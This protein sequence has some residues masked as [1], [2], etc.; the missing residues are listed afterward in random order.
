M[1][2]KVKPTSGAA[3][4]G[5]NTQDEAAVQTM[6][7]D[8]S[9]L[10]IAA[11]FEQM[12]AELEADEPETPTNPDADEEQEPGEGEGEE[13]EDEGEDEGDDAGAEGEG[14]EDEGDDEGEDEGEGDDEDEAEGED[15]EKLKVP[16]E[17]QA[18][19]DARIGKEVAKRKEAEES[20]QAQQKVLLETTQQTRELQ[21]KLAQAEATQALSRSGNNTL[22][23]TDDP[24]AI[25][26][27][28]SDINA[29][30]RWAEAN[31][32]GYESEDGS[33]SAEQIRERLVTLRQ[34]RDVEIPRIRES[35]NARGQMD[36]MIADVYP[37]LL[38]PQSDEHRI[39]QTLVAKMPWL[40]TFPGYKLWIGDAMAG[41]KL[42]REAEAKS[43]P[44]KK[45]T[46]VPKAPKTPKARGGPKKATTTTRQEPTI[47]H[48]R[49]A[50]A[51]YDPELVAEMLD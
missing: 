48:K 11:I 42:R 32:D 35:L 17:V 28:V 24:A 5:V 25:E 7:E 27:R 41:E 26:K 22:W 30:E 39:M 21:T 43:R 8:D 19:I 37:E 36:R 18:K 13:G 16:P 47:D 29:F 1:A 44:K 49:L 38:N 51:G 40:K 12:D 33:Y 15:G 14:D 6:G 9:A 3:T 50:E 20:L 46:P 34:E 10:D 4:A 45:P 31:R 23:L 2:A